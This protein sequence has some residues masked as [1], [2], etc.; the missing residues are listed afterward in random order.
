MCVSTKA[1]Q[2]WNNMCVTSETSK[3]P[4]TSKSNAM[5]KWMIFVTFIGYTFRVTITVT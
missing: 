4:D 3:A 1:P 2:G 5:C